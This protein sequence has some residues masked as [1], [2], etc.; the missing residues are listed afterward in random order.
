MKFH[1]NIDASRGLLCRVPKSELYNSAAMFADWR[2]DWRLRF[3]KISVQHIETSWNIVQLCQA[4]SSWLETD[5]CDNE[6]M[7]L[8]SEAWSVSCSMYSNI[9]SASNCFEFLRWAPANACHQMLAG[10]L[11]D[12]DEVGR[13]R[14][15]EI[16]FRFRWVEALTMF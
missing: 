5:F 16:G 6:T 13:W 1:E 14:L 4:M 7:F 2:L 10:W 11:A 15:A 8:H 9:F 12:D 3:Q